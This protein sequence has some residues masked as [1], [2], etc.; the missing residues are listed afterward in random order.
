[1]SGWIL[2]RHTFRAHLLPLQV[3]AMMEVYWFL[4]DFGRYLSLSPFSFS[5]FEGGELLLV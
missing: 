5:D 2:I 1:M 4:R 3:S